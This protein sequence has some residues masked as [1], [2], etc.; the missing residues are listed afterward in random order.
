MSF[1]VIVYRN[2]SPSNHVNKSLHLIP[3]TNLVGELRHG[4]SI[5]DPIIEFQANAP[6]F[7]LNDANYL[8]IEMFR[9][10]YYITN[11][12]STHYKLWEIHC[13]VD[14][15][16]SYKDQILANTAVVARQEN[17][18]NM[19]LDDGIFM[20]YQDP[21]I[22]TKYFSEEGPFENQEFVLLVA[23]S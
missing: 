4:T 2:D 12:V 13:H 14:V 6:G 21:I 19:M 9:R 3:N 1:P 22:E 8:Y 16:M 17:T 18:Y 15:L 20:A 23:G 5:I 10:Y 7:H 11:I